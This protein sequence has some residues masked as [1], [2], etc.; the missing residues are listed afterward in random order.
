MG[1]VSVPA[2]VSPTLFLSVASVW[3]TVV[4]ISVPFGT[5]TVAAGSGALATAAGFAAAGFAG[6]AFAAALVGSLVASFEQPTTVKR[7]A[8]AKASQTFRYTWEWNTLHLQRGTLGVSGMR[9]LV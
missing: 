6:A 3:P 7:A 5:V 1:E 4:L 8:P 9:R 2:K